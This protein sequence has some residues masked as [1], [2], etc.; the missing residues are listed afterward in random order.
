MIK[1]ILA[2]LSSTRRSGE[3]E[4]EIYASSM[5]L[6]GPPGVGEPIKILKHNTA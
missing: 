1:D 3:D 5:L 2:S 4:G 6:L